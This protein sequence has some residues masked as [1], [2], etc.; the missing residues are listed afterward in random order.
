M[1]GKTVIPTLDAYTQVVGIRVTELDSG[2]IIESYNGETTSKG[3][4]TVVAKSPQTICFR[5][6]DHERSLVEQV[7]DHHEQSMSAFLRTVIM[8]YCSAYIDDIGLDEFV[9]EV[10][11]IADKK[12][13]RRKEEE[14]RLKAAEK[15][16]A[17]LKRRT[18]TIAAALAQRSSGV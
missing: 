12:E 15:K 14:E 5:A 10:Q 4:V 2:C 17:D 1:N 6:S 16:E 18:T 8:N 9:A 7:A 13:R 11:A 3:V